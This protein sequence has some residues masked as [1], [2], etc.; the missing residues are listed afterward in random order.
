MLEY[1]TYIACILVLVTVQRNNA[2]TLTPGVHTPLQIPSALFTDRP[3]SRCEQNDVQPLR[4]LDLVG[5]QGLQGSAVGRR[6]GS[7]R[8]FFFSFFSLRFFFTS[9]GLFFTHPSDTDTLPFALA[10]HA[11][12]RD[13]GSLKPF[14]WFHRV[15]DS[16]VAYI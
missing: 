7:L 6:V 9:A 8:T 11:Q 14:H 3:R 13:S 15:V 12:S 10:K 16:G 5:Q 1:F 2:I 4:Q